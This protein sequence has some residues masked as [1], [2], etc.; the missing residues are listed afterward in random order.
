MMNRAAQLQ[1]MTGGLKVWTKEVKDKHRERRRYY[2]KVPKFSDAR[3]LCCKLPKIQT[4]T[5]NPE[6]ILSK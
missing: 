4:K 3:K 2:R 1:K 6:D 5:P